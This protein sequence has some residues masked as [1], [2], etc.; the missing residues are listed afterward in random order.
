M[1]ATV[2]TDWLKKQIEHQLKQRHTVEED[3]EAGEYIEITEQLMKAIEAT[4]RISC[5]FHLLSPIV[6]EKPGKGLF[7]LKKKTQKRKMP[8]RRKEY[9]LLDMGEPLDQ[10]HLLTSAML[11]QGAPKDPKLMVKKTPM[12]QST[13][14]GN[15]V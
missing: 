2:K 8:D 7:M 5:K 6:I 3:E 14:S 9:E 4:P 11:F 15:Q 12:K 10:Q 13:T 1:L